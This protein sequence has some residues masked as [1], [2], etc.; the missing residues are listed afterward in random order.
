MASQRTS[1][2]HKA[3][4]A[5][6]ALFAASRVGPTAPVAP[7]FVKLSA[8]NAKL[9][10]AGAGACGGD[11]CCAAA[12][13]GAGGGVPGG[14]GTAQGG[15][16]QMLATH[17]GRNPAQNRFPVQPSAVRDALK[18][19]QKLEENPDSAFPET[20]LDAAGRRSACQP[21]APAVVG[22]AHAAQLMDLN[23]VGDN[24]TVTPAAEGRARGHLGRTE[25]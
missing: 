8:A 5:T 19:G 4:E 2:A 10:P 20:D 12:A 21:D 3:P 6:Y 24:R 7:A 11:G 9:A 13:T 14:G 25:S 16:A 17:A 23:V 22:H 15:G 1:A 18:A